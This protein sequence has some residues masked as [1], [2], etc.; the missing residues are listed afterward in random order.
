MNVRKQRTSVDWAEEIQYLVASGYP[1][2][3]KITLVLDNLNTHTIASLYRAFPPEEARK[4]V[5]P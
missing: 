1:E 5:R 3:E 2:V 4:I